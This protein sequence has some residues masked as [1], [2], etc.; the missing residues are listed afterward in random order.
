M[1]R[2]GIVVSQ[3]MDDA[4]RTMH[5]AQSNVPSCRPPGLHKA[6]RR[7]PPPPPAPPFWSAS[8]PSPSSWV[9]WSSPGTSSL[10]RFENHHQEAKR[11]T[12][13]RVQ[14]LRARAKW[15]AHPPDQLELDMKCDREPALSRKNF[16]GGGVPRKSRKMRPCCCT[17]SGISPAISET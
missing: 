16:A 6:Q 14:Q 7:P 4:S 5:S 8:R 9:A 12:H 2:R 3:S 15:D 17:R 11:K 10:R 13:V 1:I